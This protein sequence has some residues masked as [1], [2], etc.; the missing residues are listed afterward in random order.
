MET[1][2]HRSYSV[3]SQTG[4]SEKVTVKIPDE[5][6]PYIDKRGC[7][8]IRPANSY[9]FVLNDGLLCTVDGKPAIRY[10]DMKGEFHTVILT[11]IE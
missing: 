1:T 4:Y 2:I 8:C 5:L 6:D 11:V 10:F 7:L 9:I 3:R